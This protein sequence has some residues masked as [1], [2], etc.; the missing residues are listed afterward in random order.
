M[1]QFQQIVTPADGTHFVCVIHTSPESDDAEGD[2][3]CFGFAYRRKGT[4]VTSMITIDHVSCL[5]NPLA[6]KERGL[7]AIDR[8]LANGAPPELHELQSPR[9][10]CPLDGDQD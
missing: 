3:Y 1:N 2:T 10:K 9:V 5:G 7:C 8:S 4:F 6:E